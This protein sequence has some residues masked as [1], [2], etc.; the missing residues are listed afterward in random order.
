MGTLMKK[1]LAITILSI[2]L[3]LMLSWG[4]TNT[5]IDI[6]TINHI[7]REVY[8]SILRGWGWAIGLAGIF[9][10]SVV[11]PFMIVGND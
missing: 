3:V 9:L 5:I 10:I 8:L 11:G 7:N 4:I 1:K 6:N 2:W